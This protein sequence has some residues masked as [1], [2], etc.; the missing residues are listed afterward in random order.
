MEITVTK[1]RR[2]PLVASLVDDVR[3]GDRLVVSGPVGDRGFHPVRDTD[4]LVFIAR[5]EGMIGFISTIEHLLE[6]RPSARVLVLHGARELDDLPF[7][8]RLHHL[9]EAHRERLV[10]KLFLARPPPDWSGERGP[11]TADAVGRVAIGEGLEQ[12]TFFLGGPVSVSKRLREELLSSGVRPGRIRI[13]RSS[14]EGDVSRLPGWPAGIS[15]E[16]VFTIRLPER[17]RPFRALAGEPLLQA[18]ERQRVV[19]S[20][21]CRSGVCGACRVRLTQGRVFT[22]P[23][24]PVRSDD[25]AAGYIYACVSYPLSDLTVALT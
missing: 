9:S 19:P 25:R 11:L 7:R 17:D 12:K 18:L 24:A 10:L 20:V 14:G 22:A 15:H 5:G 4:D 1:R 21:P 8:E 2:D 23:G 13:A 16:S 6:T 3:R